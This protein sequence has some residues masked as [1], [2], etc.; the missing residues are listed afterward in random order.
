MKSNLKKL[1]RQEQKEINGGGPIRKCTDSSQC[2][3]GECCSGG[4]C[5][6]SPYPICE[7]ILE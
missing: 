6:A 5:I 2:W 4:M 1:S 7:P 3:A